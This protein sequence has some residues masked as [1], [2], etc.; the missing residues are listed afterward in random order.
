MK[1]WVLKLKQKFD[2]EE[3][4]YESCV[5]DGYIKPVSAVNKE[6]I[7]LLMKNS[8]IS[9]D[10]ADTLAKSLK[11]GDEKWMTVYI[12]HYD[13][14]RISAEAFLLFDKIS[15]SNHLCLF[16]V[17]CVKHPELEFDW[18]F[19]EKIRTKRN[20]VNYYGEQVSYDEWKVVELQFNL[21]I[22]ALKK[23]IDKRVEYIPE[24]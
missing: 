19:L 7:R 6:R 8:G 13:V 4:A 14:L 15:S 20:G 21:Y 9:A 2:N 17:L 22:S 23:E 5:A 1:I 18:N 24:D 12:L 3:E 11:Q 16:S 10:S